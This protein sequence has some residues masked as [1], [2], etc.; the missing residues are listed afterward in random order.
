MAMESEDFPLHRPAVAPT[1]SDLISIPRFKSNPNPTEGTRNAS[2]CHRPS[3]TS[4]VNVWYKSSLQNWSLMRLTPDSVPFRPF[5]GPFYGCH[6]LRLSCQRCSFQLLPA[7]P[8]PGR[9]ASGED[10]PSAPP[11]LCAVGPFALATK[12]HL[13][14]KVFEPYIL[15]T[16]HNYMTII[17]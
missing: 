13:A 10:R 2:K 7:R 15:A 12:S 14:P 9:G 3:L 6:M 11:R 1:H 5:Y 16:I 8:A 17:I 4:P